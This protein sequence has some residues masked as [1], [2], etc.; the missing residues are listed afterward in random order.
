[1]GDSPSEASSPSAVAASAASVSLPLRRRFTGHYFQNSP[2]SSDMMTGGG[3]ETPSSPDGGETSWLKALASHP[4][5]AVLAGIAHLVG[6]GRVAST[7]SSVSLA[8]L[9]SVDCD[10]E[11]YDLTFQQPSASPADYGF[12]VA[13][14]PPSGG[15]YHTIA[16]GSVEDFTDVKIFAK[17]LSAAPQTSSESIE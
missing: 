4:V 16:S 7:L 10:F 15:G 9:H 11:E 3:C 14:T 5:L 12:Y 1:M 8:S 17:M 2:S 6:F 13:I